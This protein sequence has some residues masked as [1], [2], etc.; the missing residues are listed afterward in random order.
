MASVWVPFVSE[1][2]EAIAPYP[3]IVKEMKLAI[4]DAGRE[5]SR[6]LSGKRRAGEQKRRILIF[7]RYS[8]EVAEA[9]ARITG[10]NKNEIEKKLKSY[11]GERVKINEAGE[12][13]GI[14][15]AKDEIPKE[16]KEKQKPKKEKQLTLKGKKSREDGEK[17]D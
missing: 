15:G 10:K 11:I 1:S 7:E 2:K 5:L 4:Q 6:Y 9:L 12:V 13:E 14:E 3:D 8:T 17:E 16:E